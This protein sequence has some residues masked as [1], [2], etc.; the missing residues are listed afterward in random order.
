MKDIKVMLVGL[1]ALIGVGYRSFAAETDT[2]LKGGIYY[3]NIEYTDNVV[4]NGVDG[5]NLD[6]NA[7]FTTPGEYYE[8]YFDIVNSTKYD[9]EISEYLC[10]DDDRHID[11]ELVYED[12]SMI[13]TGDIIEK[14][15]SKRIKYRV[16]YKEAIKQEEDYKFDTSFSILYEQVM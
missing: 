10:N 3:D 4:F 2:N 7:S 16:L 8:L 1:L 11:Y 5:V 9:I 15:Q 14:G 6:Y 13:N 12:G